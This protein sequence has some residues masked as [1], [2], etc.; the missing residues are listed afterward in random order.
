MARR[1]RHFFKGAIFHVMFRGNKGQS[2]FSSDE[3]RCR[4]C[5]L[6]QEGVERFGHRILAFCFMTNHIHLAIQVNEV[7]LS[8]ICQN[9]L[10][11]YTVFCNKRHKTVGHLFQGRFKSVLVD[12]DRYLKELVRYIHL[13]P[14][15][16]HL[17]ADPLQYRWS[18]HQAYMMKEEFTWLSIDECLQRFSKSRSEAVKAFY[19]YVNAGINLDTD[20]D[21]HG[22]YKEGILGDDEFVEKV[23]QQ[24]EYSAARPLTV[25]FKTLLSFITNW[26]DIDPESLRAPG[27]ERR[28]SHIRSVIGLFVRDIQGASLQQLADFCG[29]EASGMSKAAARLE[30]RMGKSSALKTEFES[31]KVEL[32]GALINRS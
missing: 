21:F 29:R 17:V 28:S 4:F 20:I 12:S 6:M 26:Y 11:R 15:R 25:D 30:A 16:A 31:L 5:L 24:F 18:S 10:F 7:S 1:R 19:E 8:K 9:L 27:M 14:V 2:V 22:G 23:Q 3:E 32:F 13:N